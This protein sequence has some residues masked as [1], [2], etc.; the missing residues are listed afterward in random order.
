MSTTVQLKTNLRCQSCLQTIQPG[1]DAMPG[2]VRWSADLSSPDKLL[3][4]EGNQV[5]S[6]QVAGLLER[7]GFTALRLPS[8]AMASS[9]AQTTPTKTSYYPLILILVFLLGVCLFV[10]L[11]Y[12]TFDWMRSMNHFMAGFFLVFSFFKLLDVRGFAESYSGYD[13]IAARWQPYG[14]LYPFVE[15]AL[16]ILYLTHMAPI[17]TNSATI[18]VMSLGTVGVAQSLLKRRKI[19]CACLGAVFNLPMSSVTLIE[20][21]L[22]LVMAL[23]MLGAM[24]FR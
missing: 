3:T 5:S 22:M 16:G 6:E 18:L 21:L 2:V 9:S 20:D 24:L 13:I 1:L 17:F 4:V 14:Y 11:G 8:V 7:H 12:G 10:E 15:L 23:A 19:R